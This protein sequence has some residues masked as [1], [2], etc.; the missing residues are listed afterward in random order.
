VYVGHQVGLLQRWG[1]R[2]GLPGA[3]N[4]ELLST[5]TT[6]VAFQDAAIAFADGVMAV[7]TC[8]SLLVFQTHTAKFNGTWSV[9]HDDYSQSPGMVHGDEVS[10]Q[11][12]ETPHIA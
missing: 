3:R 6:G 5:M 1:S 7:S 12:S 2:D 11:I 8:T 9:S 4:V 10:H